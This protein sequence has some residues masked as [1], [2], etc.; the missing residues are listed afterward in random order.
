VGL[1]RAPILSNFRTFSDASGTVECPHALNVKKYSEIIASLNSNADDSS[2]QVS[3]TRALRQAL[4]EA[5][6]SY[7]E[8]N[9]GGPENL[10]LHLTSR[11]ETLGALHSKI[12][13]AAQ[14]MAAVEAAPEDS[15][16]VD[17]LRSKILN[18]AQKKI[19][20][21]EIAV[22][23]SEKSDEAIEDAAEEGDDVTEDLV[24]ES[25]IPAVTLTF[26]TTPFETVAAAFSLLETRYG[27]SSAEVDAKEGKMTQSSQCKKGAWLDLGSGD[28]GPTLAAALLRHWPLGCG[29]LEVRKSLHQQAEHVAIAYTQHQDEIKA[30]TGG[31]HGSA[32]ELSFVNGDFRRNFG[33][34]VQVEN[35]S[36]LFL[37]A[38]CFDDGL[39][40]EVARL[41]VP[42]LPAG[43]FV[44]SAS[45]PLPSEALQTLE[46]R[47]V[48]FRYSVEQK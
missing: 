41:I 17:A 20:A 34:G 13:D 10:G 43:A 47:R 12:L 38:T 29:G 28:G 6:E 35:V 37:H 25:P 1:K 4:T 48:P 16:K 11:L 45:K 23:P 9:E 26:G 42:R 33:G 7:S 24:T 30:A 3:A 32:Q 19:E 14:S 22:D 39:M 15:Q 46:A 2:S 8:A 36:V 27:L 18:A 40:Q 5:D 21:I 44:V 31:S